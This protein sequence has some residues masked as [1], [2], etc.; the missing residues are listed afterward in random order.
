MQTSEGVR[1]DGFRQQAMLLF[2]DPGGQGRDIIIGQHGNRGLR[3]D[4]PAIDILG[5]EV[6][7]AA[8]NLDAVL[9]SLS[10]RV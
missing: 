3:D 5:D 8:R 10:L 4:R 2:E 7:R 1:P 9:Q 6:Y